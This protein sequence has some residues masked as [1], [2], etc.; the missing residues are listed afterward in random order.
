MLSKSQGN[1]FAAMHPRYPIFKRLPLGP[2]EGHALLQE[3]LSQGEIEK[4]AFLLRESRQHGMIAIDFLEDGKSKAANNE[5]WNSLRLAYKE[6]GWVEV[7][8][9]TLTEMKASFESQKGIMLNGFMVSRPNN[10][11]LPLLLKKLESLGFDLNDMV[12]AQ[13]NEKSAYLS[14]VFGEYLSDQEDKQ[15]GP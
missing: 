13:G 12:Y 4:N 3:K 14:D 2:E 15:H 8:I 7:T 11:Y 9:D 10:P 1:L 5:D 6:M